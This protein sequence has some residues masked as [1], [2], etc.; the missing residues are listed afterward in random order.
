[1]NLEEN[2]ADAEC[3]AMCHITLLE[4]KPSANPLCECDDTLC[5]IKD[6]LCLLSFRLWEVQLEMRVP[7][8]CSS[9]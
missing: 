5:E 4:Q 2:K 7:A 1:M 3:G 6:K 8:D 9:V